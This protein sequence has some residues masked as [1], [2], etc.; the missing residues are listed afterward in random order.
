[1]ATDKEYIAE[2]Q[3]LLAR[4]KGHLVHR[5]FRA[6]KGCKNF[7]TIVVREIDADD[8]L[9]AS[10]RAA[11]KLK[12]FK[13]PS[14]GEMMRADRHEQLRIAI[15]AV[16]GTATPETVGGFIAF[17]RWSQ[18]DKT[19][20]SRFFGELNGLDTEELEKSV[21]ASVEVDPKRLSESANMLTSSLSVSAEIGS[22]EQQNG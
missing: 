5:V 12:R 10:R 19:A 3:E 8:E 9:V 21:A 20:V 1:M 16:D 22:T 7:K 4:D 11:E 15:A 6:S 17:D 13:D 18:A 14:V 2:L